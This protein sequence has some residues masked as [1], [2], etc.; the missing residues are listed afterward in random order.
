MEDGSGLGIYIPSLIQPEMDYR[1]QY[2]TL[3]KGRGNKNLVMPGFKLSSVEYANLINYL[4]EQYGNK[5]IWL[6]R[7][8]EN[9]KCETD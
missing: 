2:C 1:L 8:F 5:K 7:D 9:L 3:L 6:P 4:N